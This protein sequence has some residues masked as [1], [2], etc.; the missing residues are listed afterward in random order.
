MKEL[1]NIVSVIKAA[2]YD[3]MDSPVGTLTLITSPQGL[4]AVL[5]DVDFKADL[6]KQHLKRD[7]RETTIVRAKTQLQEYFNHERE[8]FDLPLVMNGTP[9]QIKAWQQLQKIPYAATISYAEQAR[10][11]GDKRLARAVG[12]ANGQ[13]PLS[14]IVPCHRVI[15][16][17]GKLVGFG[18]GLDRKITL[19]TLEQRLAHH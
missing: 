8:Q 15:G 19:L 5:W 18:G 6:C 1:K 9:F 11:M 17:N 2:T 16:S 7:K 13:N 14:I 4:H 12:G 10:R 3:E